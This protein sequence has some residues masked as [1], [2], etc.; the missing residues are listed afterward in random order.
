MGE[1]KEG[2]YSGGGS[3]NLSDEGV[4]FKIHQLKS[5][6]GSEKNSQANLIDRDKTDLQAHSLTT[7]QKTMTS[8]PKS[9]TSISTITKL[10]LPA[11]KPL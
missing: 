2:D 8:K 7:R 4:S 3:L 11:A 1:G 9:P 5:R 10:I 6:Y